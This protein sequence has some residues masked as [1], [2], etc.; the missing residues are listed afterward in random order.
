MTKCVRKNKLKAM[1]QFIKNGRTLSAAL[2]IDHLG[3]Y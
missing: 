2:V 1:E 3:L